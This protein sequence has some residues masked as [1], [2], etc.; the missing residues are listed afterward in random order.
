M[1]IEIQCPRLIKASELCHTR[2]ILFNDSYRPVELLRN[3]FVGP[4]VH[5]AYQPEAVEAKFGGS[6]EALAL[7]PFTFYGRERSYSRLPLAR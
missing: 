4:N 2:A 6:D 7:Q 3:A 5:A 1:R